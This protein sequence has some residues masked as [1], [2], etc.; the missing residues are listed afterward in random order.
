MTEIVD[1]QPNISPGSL[2]NTLDVSNH[3]TVIR[4]RREKC[5][6][7]AVACA[8]TSPGFNS[9]AL[10]EHGRNPRL[11]RCM[12]IS[13]KL[14]YSEES[15]MTSGENIVE[16]YRRIHPSSYL[17]GKCNSCSHVSRLGFSPVCYAQTL[18]ALASK[19]FAPLPSS[20]TSKSGYSHAL[21]AALCTTTTAPCKRMGRGECAPSNLV[22]AA[23][24]VPP[25]GCD[26]IADNSL[27]EAQ[28]QRQPPIYCCLSIL[29][30][31]LPGLRELPCDGNGESR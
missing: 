16:F 5:G 8:A 2:A 28:A 17:V 9:Q 25:V 12:L 19:S 3:K 13:S 23:V 24:R 27:L 29:V 15:S 18:D 14:A 6:Y 7:N 20:N 11:G 21:H 26:A 4:L 30:N 22:P 1:I 31:T 10:K